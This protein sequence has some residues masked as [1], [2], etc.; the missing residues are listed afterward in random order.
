MRVE[1]QYGGVRAILIAR[2]MGGKGTLTLELE[3]SVVDL[4]FLLQQGLDTLDPLFLVPTDD[5][6][7][8]PEDELFLKDERLIRIR[9]R[10]PRVIP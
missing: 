7:R 9:I 4:F 6:V 1:R 5:L 2:T 8:D 10:F 3:G